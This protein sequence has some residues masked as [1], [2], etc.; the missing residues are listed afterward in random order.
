MK[1]A[2]VIPSLASDD[3]YLRACIDS[4]DELDPSPGEVLVYRNDGSQGLGHVRSKLFDEAFNELGCDVVL[5]CSSDFQL[6]PDILNYVSGEKITTFAYFSRKLSMPIQL[7]KFL[8]SPGMWTGCY[9]ITREFWDLFRRTPW[10]HG[11]D[12][13]DNGIVG[14]ASE[15]GYPV[16]RVRVPKYALLRPSERMIEFTRGLPLVK[17][18]LKLGAWF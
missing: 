15:Y 1:I 6:F 18:I 4:V 7:F 14:C 10:F 2:V 3:D 17:K 9:S 5:Q 11:W 8:I 16:K 13:Q 12:G